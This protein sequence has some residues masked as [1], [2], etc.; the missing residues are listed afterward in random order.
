M[1]RERERERERREWTRRDIRGRDDGG[2]V[3]APTLCEERSENGDEECC[4]V[5][6]ARRSVDAL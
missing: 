1:G 5:R 4:N 2:I 3:R 6:K